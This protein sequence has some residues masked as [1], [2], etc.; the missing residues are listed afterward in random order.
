MSRKVPCPEDSCDAPVPFWKLREHLSRHDGCREWAVAADGSVSH[1]WNLADR[2]EASLPDLSW[3]C[4]LFNFQGYYFV[5][6]FSKVGKY[7]AM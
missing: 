1:T 5:P 2:F 4:T 7:F 3:N 6:V